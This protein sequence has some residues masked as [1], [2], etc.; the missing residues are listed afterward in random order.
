MSQNDRHRRRAHLR[1]EEIVSYIDQAITAAMRRQVEGHLAE[2]EAC[3]REV[4][5]VTRLVR[6]RVRV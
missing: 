4:I 5:E 1:P 3:L 2:C 6:S